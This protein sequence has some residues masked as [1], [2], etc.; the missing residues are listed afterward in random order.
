MVQ[1][2]VDRGA[3][4]HVDRGADARAAVGLELLRHPSAA[5]PS[6]SS[7][8]TR[9]ALPGQVAADG[10]AHARTAAGDHRDPAHLDGLSVVQASTLC[11]LPTF[12]G[13]LARQHAA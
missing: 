9:R 13:P 5:S 6:M 12:A 1:R 11:R 3:V 2:G 4:A 7:T 8:A 10:A